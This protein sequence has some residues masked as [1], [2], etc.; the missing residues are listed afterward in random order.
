MSSTTKTTIRFGEETITLEASLDEVVENFNEYAQSLKPKLI[1]S[2][3]TGCRISLSSNAVLHFLDKCLNEKLTLNPITPNTPPGQD[4]VGFKVGSNYG[5]LLL[6]KGDSVVYRALEE[7][8]G[9][10]T[11]TERIKVP[12]SVINEWKTFISIGDDQYI[13][14]PDENESSLP[15]GFLQCLHCPHIASKKN[16]K[17]HERIHTDETPYQCTQ[18][19]YGAPDRANLAYHLKTHA[20]TRPHK[21]DQCDFDFPT[22]YNLRRHKL[23]HMGGP[24]HRCPHCNYETRQSSNLTRHLK[25]HAPAE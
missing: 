11:K 7:S 22:S 1:I 14:A 6:D 15:E 13:F 25:V 24:F 18:C 4:C 8:K 23:I 9:I 20:G 2:D 19:P 10:F 12:R 21:C 3:S 5:L 16:M 17:Q